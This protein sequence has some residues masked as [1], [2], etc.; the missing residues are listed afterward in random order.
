[1]IKYL[2][3]HQLD[4]RIKELE[5]ELEQWK[6]SLSAADIEIILDR[7]GVKLEELDDEDYQEHW[8]EATSDGE[9]FKAINDLKDEL[10]SSWDDISCLVAERDFEE[11]AEQE[12]IEI[13]A[14]RGGYMDWPNNC[15]D[16]SKA[17]DE[18]K[19]DY[20]QVDF[21]GETYYYRA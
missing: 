14:I 21:E 15:I 13:G 12:A 16:W 18:L 3:I 17:A 1:M 19:Q 11:F 4:E 5:E 20:S 7:F 2:H 6:T 10:G 8:T 9:E